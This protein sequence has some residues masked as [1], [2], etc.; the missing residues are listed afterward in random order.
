MAKARIIG[1]VA[2]TFVALILLWV[3]GVWAAPTT[4]EQARTAVANWLVLSPQPLGASLSPQ[5][6]DV[7]TFADASGPLYFV[8]YLEPAGLVLLPADDLAEPIIGFAPEATAYDPSPA[9]P[10]GALANRDIPLRV[11]GI[12]KSQAA[13]R[14]RGQEFAPTGAM[15]QAQ[16]KWQLLAQSPPPEGVELGAASL[17]DVRVAPLVQSKWDQDYVGSNYCYNHY[18]PNHYLCGCTATAMAQVMRYHQHPT[19]GVGTPSFTI[20]V[21]GVEQTASL[22]GGDGSGGPYNWALMPLVPDDFTPLNELQ[23]IGAL[24]Y[25]AGVA[26]NTSYTAAASGAVLDNGKAFQNVFYYGNARVG[27]S[28]NDPIPGDNLHAMIIPNLYARLP[29][30]LRIKGPPGAHAI[31]TDGYGEDLETAY[32]HLNMGWAGLADAWYNLGKIDSDSYGGPG[33]FTII[34]D[35]VYNIYPFGAGEI[36]SGRVVD[37]SGQPISGAVVGMDNVGVR[38]TNDQGIFAFTH[39][40]SNSE[41]TIRIGAQDHIFVPITVTTGTSTDDTFDCGNAGCPRSAPAAAA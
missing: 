18:T 38:Y 12:R 41:C 29:V 27:W 23:Q 20:K 32:F 11:M 33:P 17:S 22:R 7:Q 1:R 5:I 14:A 37:S 30:L 6:R 4:A 3:S 19:V 8:V 26:I 16:K 36:V 31:L 25:D 9:N 28:G 24:V 34:T 15:R 13:A 39:L 40:A 21:D 35:C 2:L 10:L